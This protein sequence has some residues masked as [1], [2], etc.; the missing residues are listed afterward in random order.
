MTSP[1][2]NKGYTYPAHG[3][4]VNAWD[5]P[6]NTNFDQIDLNV[7]GMYPITISSTITGVTYSS[8]GATASSTAT[9]LTFPSSL[10]QNLYYP[11]TGTLTQ[12]LDLVFPAVGSIYAI[13]NGSS[14]SFNVTAYPAGSSAAAVTITQGGG[15]LVVMNST[16]AQF[17]DSNFLKL[18]PQANNTIVGNV[19]GASAAPI[20]LGFGSGLT[21]NSTA[22][23]VSAAFAPPSR[24]FKKLSIKVS[25]T[26]TVTMAADF[27]VVT[28][29]T[30]YLTVPLTATICNLGTA[31][32]ANGLDQG[33]IA[34]S[35]F[36]SMYVIYN[37][38]TNVVA[39]L[40]STSVTS[41]LLPS[42]FTFYARYGLVLTDSSVAQLFGSWQFGDTLQW[43]IGLA[44][45]AALPIIGTPGTAVTA[46]T[47]IS[48]SAYVPTTAARVR[49][50]LFCGMG[51][52]SAAILAPN[53]NYSNNTSYQAT[54][55]NP[56]PVSASI[57]NGGNG[58]GI[59]VPFDFIIESTSL[60]WGAH[61]T[62]NSQVMLTGWVDNL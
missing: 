20:A 32:V 4:A 12:G 27:V 30:Y 10:A 24:S 62:G 36:Y 19:S 35:T 53:G 51:A 8:S 5:S 42:G 39:T 22:S 54:P 14:G 61:S 15:N 6:L 13:N 60:F 55:T 49:G 58:V 43:V 31:G 25:T 47:S 2:P 7:G 33:A 17:A 18:P 26:T 11:L 44:R 3:G 29:G 1:T 52:G 28:D 38:T 48:M 57:N 45:T 16:R 46:W 50:I 41:P 21:P 37:P 59:A 9:S 23:T 34:T 40:A 56:P